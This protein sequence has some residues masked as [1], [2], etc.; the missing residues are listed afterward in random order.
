MANKEGD[1]VSQAAR[2]LASLVSRIENVR[3]DLLK[4]AQADLKAVYDEAKNAGYDVKVLR[5]II[6]RRAK[7]KEEVET[8]DAVLA[9]YETNLDSVMD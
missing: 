3:D 8:F 1:N 7:K 2:S 5:E 4:P 9:T 6:K